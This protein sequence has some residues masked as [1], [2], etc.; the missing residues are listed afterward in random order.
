MPT[1]RYCDH[2]PSEIKIGFG[3]A[4]LDL[5]DRTTDRV[6]DLGPDRLR[7][8]RITLRTFLDHPLE[9]ALGEGDTGSLDH[10]QI[11]RTRQHA[12]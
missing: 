10:L 9:H 2:K 5:G 4:R 1:S 7:P 6:A 12:P 11:D 8:L 3:R